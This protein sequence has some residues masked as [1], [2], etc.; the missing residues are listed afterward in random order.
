MDRLSSH[1]HLHKSLVM[2]CLV[3]C[4]S[5]CH[6]NRSAT[7][8]EDV[9]ESDRGRFSMWPKTRSKAKAVDI[10]TVSGSEDGI[11]IQ[12]LNH[13]EKSSAKRKW[14]LFGDRKPA[15]QGIDLPRTDTSSIKQTDPSFP[16]T[17]NFDGIE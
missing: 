11:T 8:K 9:A 10:Q 4:L 7:Y 1:R 15:T 17:H 2:L 12:P 3:G 14:P 16:T 5:G 6:L 13:E